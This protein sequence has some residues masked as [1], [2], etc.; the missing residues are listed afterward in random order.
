MKYAGVWNNISEKDIEKMKRDIEK[1][2]KK[3]TREI[4]N[5]SK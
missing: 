3:S 2:R 1:L 4:L 5:K